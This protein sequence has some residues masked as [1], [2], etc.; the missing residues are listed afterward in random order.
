[1]RPISPSS[2]INSTVLEKDGPENGVARTGI[3]RKHAQDCEDAHSSKQPR[4][5]SPTIYKI[6][7]E[8]LR[9]FNKEM[10]TEVSDSAGKRSWSQRTSTVS[11][12]KVSGV[13]NAK[14]RFRVLKPAE[15]RFHTDPPRHIE[16]AISAIVH[17]KPS[18]GRR[19]Q[20]LSIAQRFQTLCAELAGSPSGEGNFVAIFREIVDLMG[21]DKL[22]LDANVDWDVNLKPKV[23][24][25]PFNLDLLLSRGAGQGQQQQ[26]Q[27]GDSSTPAF[28]PNLGRATDQPQGPSASPTVDR[29]NTSSANIP[30]TS[31]QM[32]SPPR[33][34]EVLKTPR[35]DITMG[36]ALQALLG[37]LSEDVDEGDAEHFLEELQKETRSYGSER[38]QAP[39]L[40]SVPA[41][42][43]PDLTF[44]FCVH[45]GKA[46]LTGQQL[47][48]AENQAAVSGACALNIQLRLD[49]LV[50]GNTGQPPEAAPPS[51][52]D[53][54]APPALAPPAEDQIPLFFSICTEG[55]VHVLWAHWALDGPKRR[56]YHTKPLKCV[57]GSMSDGLLEFCIMVDNVLRWGTG[58]FLKSLVARLTKVARMA[59][60]AIS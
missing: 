25:S 15:L 20:L 1:M 24:R 16:E 18:E 39:F 52:S 50:R 46:Y 38:S 34:T 45:E 4:K 56:Q 47:G 14:Y 27:S 7:K 23:Q 28:S 57:Y 17:A 58:H 6:S 10:G 3:K 19:E 8:N 42:T 13:T 21:H 43:A 48:A 32:P 51:G 60:Q 12:T 35:P 29:P 33:P 5:V 54:V 36:V 9:L 53:R 22:R 44:P 11:S 55:P 40:I 30:P 37:A 26:Q 31:M 49:G 59:G 41:Q 2:P